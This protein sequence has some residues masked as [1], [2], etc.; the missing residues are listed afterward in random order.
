MIAGL[1]YWKIRLAWTFAEIY[2]ECVDNNGNIE[3]MQNVFIK[4]ICILF[5]RK[6]VGH[7][8]NKQMTSCGG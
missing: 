1:T 2:V 5:V 4:Q 3:T 8:K 6:D 7:I